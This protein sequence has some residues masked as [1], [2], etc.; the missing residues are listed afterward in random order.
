ML[1]DPIYCK[2]GE[3]VMFTHKNT[4]GA[5]IEVYPIGGSKRVAREHHYNKFLFD[6]C[7]WLISLNSIT[8]CYE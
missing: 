3:Y 6:N 8:L 2:S 1:Y 7:K 4:N 5:Y